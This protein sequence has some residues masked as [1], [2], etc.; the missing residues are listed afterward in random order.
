MASPSGPR[1]PGLHYRYEFFSKW[2]TGPLNDN[3][4]NYYD[5]LHRE[6]NAANRRIVQ[7]YLRRINRP[8][9]NLTR[10]EVKA[11]A[12]RLLNS[13][14]PAVRQFLARLE[15][16]NPGAVGALRSIITNFRGAGFLFIVPGQQA[17][18]NIRACGGTVCGESL[19]G[20]IF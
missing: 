17:L 9:G 18:F 4:A 2:Y 5:R 6:L 7:E 10:Q 14:D 11:L 3:R 8:I 13:N 19:E 12:R 16:M 20:G 15:Q 1:F